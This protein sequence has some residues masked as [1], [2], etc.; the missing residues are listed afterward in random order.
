MRCVAFASVV[1]IAALASGC[2]EPN[3]TNYDPVGIAAADANMELVEVPP[4]QVTSC[5]ESTKFGAYVGDVTARERWDAAGQSDAAL[6]EVCGQLGR[7]DP[8][9]LATIHW[10]WT[11][12]Q[13]SIGAASRAEVT[14]SADCDPSYPDLCLPIG[15][16]DINCDD[17]AERRFTVL[18]PDRHELDDNDNGIGCESD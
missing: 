16:P 11:A 15:G 7:T 18:A 1:V 3:T 6:S 8:A 4:E 17:V 13:S 2:K 14:P 12:A 5:V 10:N 9:A